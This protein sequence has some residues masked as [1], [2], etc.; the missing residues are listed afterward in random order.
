M[1]Q[2]HPPAN[3]ATSHFPPAGIVASPVPACSEIGCDERVGDDAGEL[4]GTEDE[5]PAT[6]TTTATNCA[7]RKYLTASSMNQ[8]NDG[9]LKDLVKSLR[10]QA[11]PMISSP[12]GKGPPED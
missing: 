11:C 4:G 9:F 6:A 7:A 1:H 8:K 5:H 2:K 12:R 3:T 10:A